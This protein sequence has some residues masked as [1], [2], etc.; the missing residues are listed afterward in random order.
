[1]VQGP[2]ME[3][4]CYLFSAPGFQ[5]AIFSIVVVVA[6]TLLSFCIRTRFIHSLSLIKSATTALTMQYTSI[7][8]A[9]IA[10]LA[11]AQSTATTSAAGSSF[12]C[13]AQA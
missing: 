13:A 3:R 7:V 11:A 9:A 5:V 6:Y 1:M 4:A 8:L 12:S 10:S 2:N